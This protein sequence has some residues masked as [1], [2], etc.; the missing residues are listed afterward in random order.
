VTGIIRGR[1]VLGTDTPLDEALATKALAQ[2]GAAL[3]LDAVDAAMAVR[4]VATAEIAAAVQR[5]L[6]YRGVDPRSLTLM[7]FGGTG[8]L[9]AA[10]VA[11]MVGIPSIV[12]PQAAGVFTTFGLLS[13]E[14]GMERSENVQMVVSGSGEQVEAKLAA[15]QEQ[16]AQMLRGELAAG[17]ELIVERSADMRFRHQVQ[18]LALNLPADR[19]SDLDVANL[20]RQEYQRQFGLSSDDDIEVVQLR[21]RVSA[22]QQAQAARSVRREPVGLR[23]LGTKDAALGESGMAPVDHYEVAGGI[24]AGP[25]RITGPA[26]VDLVHTTVVVPSGWEGGLLPNGDL[27]FS[28][29]SL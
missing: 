4:A 25:E 13:S 26:V 6:F 14:I 10:D 28:R 11:D 3:D 12:V 2:V 8:P 21:V 18:T 9:H 15:L 5:L 27:A 1:F 7:A 19:L 16:A 23:L 22:K 24:S 29:G 20:F 17:G